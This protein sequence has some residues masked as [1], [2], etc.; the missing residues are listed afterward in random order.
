MQVEREYS[1]I[2]L[3]A[4]STTLGVITGVVIIRIAVVILDMSH[5]R[6]ESTVQ[7]HPSVKVLLGQ[8]VSPSTVSVSELQLCSGILYSRRLL[9]VVGDGDGSVLESL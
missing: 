1:L 9:E 5:S 8:P 2:A 7:M 3:G 6:T 4:N